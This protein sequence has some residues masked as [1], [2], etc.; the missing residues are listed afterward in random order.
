MFVK[1]FEE[2]KVGWG[3]VKKVI[4]MDEKKFKAVAQRSRRGRWVDWK[5]WG[6]KKGKGL[7]W[8]E[9]GERR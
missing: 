4:C 9:L 3:E 2:W 5:W 8:A 6:E 7:F 1:V